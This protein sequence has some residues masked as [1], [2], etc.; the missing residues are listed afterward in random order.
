[1]L[2]L[3]GVGKKWLAGEVFGPY[4]V[5][6]AFSFTAP[7]LRGV[8]FAYGARALAAGRY[9]VY[10]APHMTLDMLGVVRTAAVLIGLLHTP[11]LASSRRR[12]PS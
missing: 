10:R 1:M 9:R 7:L 3:D 11:L 8:H 6:S 5:R 12:L 4:R 2:P